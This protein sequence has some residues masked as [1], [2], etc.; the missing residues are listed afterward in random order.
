MRGLRLPATLEGFLLGTFGV[1]GFGRCSFFGVLV[2]RFWGV[3]VYGGGELQDFS[4]GSGL[5]G[6]PV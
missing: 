2:L 4:W 1:W 5:V 6:F 3:W